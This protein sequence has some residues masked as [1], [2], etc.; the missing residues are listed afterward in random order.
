[1]GGWGFLSPL[2]HIFFP[3][4]KQGLPWSTDEHFPHGQTLKGLVMVNRWAV[5]S[6]FLL[7]LTR[8]KMTFVIF[9]QF[10]QNPKSQNPKIPN[11]Q[12]SKYPNIQISKYP[13]IQINIQKNIT[14]A[15]GLT[16]V[17]TCLFLIQ[18]CSNMH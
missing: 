1:M 15:V 7:D 8:A 14:Q 3:T 11:I 12:I 4:A 13:N 18:L 2:K 5:F 16:S 17:W 6:S 9:F 10:S